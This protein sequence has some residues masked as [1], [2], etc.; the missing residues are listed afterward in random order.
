MEFIFH[1]IERKKERK[2]DRKKERKNIRLFPAVDRVFLVS[3]SFDL[4]FFLL[5]IFLFRLS[6]SICFALLRIFKALDRRDPEPAVEGS[7]SGTVRGLRSHSGQTPPAESTGSLRAPP[8]LTA[9][10]TRGSLWRFAPRCW[11]DNP[12]STPLSF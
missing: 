5:N 10:D 11:T 8:V 1:S 9:R 2:T 7:W 4:P 12:N 6:F 3:L